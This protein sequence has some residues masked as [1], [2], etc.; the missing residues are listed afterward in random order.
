MCFSAPKP[1]K[2]PAPPS[3]HAGLQ[4]DLRER[5]RR[6]AANEMSGYNSTIL[7][8]AGGDDTDPKVKKKVLLG[9]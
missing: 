4:A 5:Q 2:A 8:S 7:T 3:Q 6:A 1:Q 9:G